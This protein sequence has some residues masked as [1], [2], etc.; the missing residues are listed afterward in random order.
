[1]SMTHDELVTRAT[2]WLQRTGGF[3]VA[4]SEFRTYSM[5]IP[6][7]IGFRAWSSAVVECKISRADFLRD[8]HKPFRRVLARAMGSQRYYMV[9]AGLISI[10]ELPE[11]WGL[12][13]VKGRHVRVIRK[14]GGFPDRS[15]QSEMAFLVSMLRRIEIRAIEVHDSLPHS[16]RPVDFL[17]QWIK[18]G[19]SLVHAP[20]EE[21]L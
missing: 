20:A 2:R 14:S 1:M 18:D 5:E 6:D 12:L 9:P 19:V 10:E 21:S 13:Y 3:T 15:W 11:K 17:N 8:K 4:F 7:A 16:A